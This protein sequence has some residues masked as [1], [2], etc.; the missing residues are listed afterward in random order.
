MSSA[1]PHPP[2][3][4]HTRLPSLTGSDTGEFPTRA[5]LGLSTVQDHSPEDEPFSAPIGLGVSTGGQ[6][7]V[8][9]VSRSAGAED[10]KG[11]ELTGGEEDGEDNGTIRERRRNGHAKTHSNGSP[12]KWKGKARAVDVDLENGM[13]V[14]MNVLEYTKVD[15]V[16]PTASYPPVSD[17]AMEERKITENLKRWEEQERQKRKAARDA[18][19][20]RSDVPGDPSL[21]GSSLADVTRRASLLFRGGRR[22]PGTADRSSLQSS[23]SDAPLRPRST[24]TPRD[25]GDAELGILNEPTSPSTAGST[26]IRTPG[27]PF[28]PQT[29]PISARQ[30]SQ[31]GSG[32]KPK[33]K[34]HARPPRNSSISSAFADVRSSDEDPFSSRSSLEQTRANE[35]PL[36]SLPPLDNDVTMSDSRWQPPLTREMTASDVP[37]S[38]EEGEQAEGDEP[39]ARRWWWMDWMC[40]CGG[41]ETDDE[42]QAGRTNPF[43]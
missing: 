19:R 28:S 43:E 36:P 34:S 10:E 12:T 33:P 30:S 20:S 41:E 11:D 42:D 21:S 24:A 8:Q 7:A 37:S 5:R 27:N 25:G 26:T 13:D 9:L 35:R 40:G 32:G 16:S 31:F 4:G 38:T 29:S 3:T 15:S 39:R 23:N 17:D 18:R 14:P 2:Q 1:R 22:R 6:S